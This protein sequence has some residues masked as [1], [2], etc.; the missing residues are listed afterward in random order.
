MLLKV[1]ARDGNQA[2]GAAGDGQQRARG[3]KLCNITYVGA[4]E[5]CDEWK[6][7]KGEKGKTWEGG[8]CSGTL[9]Q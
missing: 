4:D 8:K 6:G 7:T 1:A 3:S 5:G 2:R 9:S